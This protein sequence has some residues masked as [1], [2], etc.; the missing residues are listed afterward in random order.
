MKFLRWMSGRLQHKLH[1]FS[2]KAVKDN[3]KKH[4][5]ALVIITVAW[6]VIED[7]LFP[8][9]FGLL[10][11][12]VNPVFYGGIPV[13]WLL[14]LHWLMVPLLWGIWVKISGGKHVDHSDNDSCNHHH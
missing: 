11:K 14:C 13:A 1:H 6:E 10:G 3:L 4:G 8:V 7:V 5:I 2:L 9:L 12:Y